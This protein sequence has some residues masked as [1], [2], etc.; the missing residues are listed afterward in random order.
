MHGGGR[1]ELCGLD[2]GR[3]DRGGLKMIE[4]GRWSHNECVFSGI[5]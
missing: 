3:F 1:M 5:E 4:T 2:K